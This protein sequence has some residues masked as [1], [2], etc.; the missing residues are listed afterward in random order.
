VMSEWKM[1]GQIFIKFIFHVFPFEAHPKSY[2]KQ[3]RAASNSNVR[4][5]QSREVAPRRCHY[6]LVLLL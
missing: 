1:A 2:K 5:G 6:L 3:F 4:N